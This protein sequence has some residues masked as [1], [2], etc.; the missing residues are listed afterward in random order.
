M[1][2]VEILKMKTAIPAKKNVAVVT[3]GN[4]LRGDDSAGILFGN[5]IKKMCHMK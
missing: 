1:L 2:T 4:E 5:I 3:L